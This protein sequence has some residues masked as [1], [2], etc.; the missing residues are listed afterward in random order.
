MI[1]KNPSA[2]IVWH[3][4]GIADLLR[5]Y[6]D[7]ITIQEGITTQ[8]WLLLLYLAGDPNIPTL[9]PR[10]RNRLLMASEVAEAL[11]VSRPNVT[12]LLG[13]LLKK[14][15]V[16][17]VEDENDRR[18]KYL[19]VTP[20]GIALLER[21]E[22]GRADFNQNLTAKFTAGERA[23]LLRVL[24]SMSDSLASRYSAIQRAD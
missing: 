10:Q 1:N 15:L 17:Q 8:Q 6:G 11:N 22:P 16:E 9:E 24:R 3:F 21:L 18:R 13:I 23:T 5:K 4:L 12:N 20:P 14:E 7:L 19:R 2:E